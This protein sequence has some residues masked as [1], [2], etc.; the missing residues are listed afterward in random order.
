MRQL[1][2]KKKKE[3]IGERLTQYW[4]QQCVRW[5]TSHFVHRVDGLACSL[6]D[7]Q[8]RTGNF[9]AHVSLVLFTNRTPRLLSRDVAGRRQRSAQPQG[10]PVKEDRVDGDVWQAAF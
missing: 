3:N 2:D 5:R 8:Q 1:D 10:C 6:S 9:H 7:H 4:E